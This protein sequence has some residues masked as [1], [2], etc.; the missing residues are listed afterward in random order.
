VKNDRTSNRMENKTAN[1][2]GER[3]ISEFALSWESLGIF[4]SDEWC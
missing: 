1:Y 2:E 3:M 4:M